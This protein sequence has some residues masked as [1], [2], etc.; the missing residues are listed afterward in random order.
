MTDILWN[1]PEGQ[2]IGTFIFAHGAGAGM[3]SNFM[4]RFAQALCGHGVT[5]ARFEFD[6]MAKRRVTEKK[7]PPPKAEKLVGE[8]QRVLQE[9]Q[10]ET[11]GPLFIGGKSMGGR[12]AAMLACGSSLPKR[13]AG[14][15][16]LG[17]PFHPIGKDA[18]ENW[19]MEPLADS[20]RPIMIAQGERDQM[21]HWWELD[22]I[23]LPS[24]VTIHFLE[25]GNHDF[26]PRGQSPATW[27][28]NIKIAAEHAKNFIAS[29]AE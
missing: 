14:V 9:V 19:R 21:G 16:C 24:T 27:D 23:E 8:Y 22:E 25:D 5:V 4:E 7:A 3:D 11:E 2:S 1:R 13:V 17:Y 12:V 28:G 6:Y 26:A 20:K 10:K 15:V 18:P 29:F